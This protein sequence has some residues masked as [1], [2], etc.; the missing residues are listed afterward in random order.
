METIVKELY[1]APVSDVTGLEG[2]TCVMQASL[3]KEWDVE[4]LDD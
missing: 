2:E 1:V 4:D 3:G